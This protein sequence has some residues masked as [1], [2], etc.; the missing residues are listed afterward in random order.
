MDEVA[1]DGAWETYPLR[2]LTDDEREAHQ[3]AIRKI[4]RRV[5]PELKV[6]EKAGFLPGLF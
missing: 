2:E 4:K 5:N 3:K 6:R 1:R